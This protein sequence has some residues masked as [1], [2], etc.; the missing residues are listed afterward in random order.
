[1]PSATSTIGWTLENWGPVPET[2]TKSPSCTA[3]TDTWI[4]YTDMPVAPF[5]PEV[6][7]TATTD[8]CWP[9]PTDKSLLE[10]YADN[11][12]RVAYWS[13]GVNC[14]S[15]WTSIGQA[16]HPTDGPVT[17]SGIFQGYPGR[18]DYHGNYHL[19]DNDRT[20]SGTVMFGYKDAIGALLDPGET[21]IACCPSSM[22]VAEN[23]LC[24]ASLSSHPVSTA[25]KGGWASAGSTIVT[26]SYMLNGTAYTGPVRM[27]AT[28]SVAATPTAVT[29]TTFSAD[30]TGGL[31]AMSMEGPIFMA[32]RESDLRSLKS[33]GTSH[34]E[35]TEKAGKWD[36]CL[37]CPGPVKNVDSAMSSAT[38]YE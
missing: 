6:C 7:V 8:I 36:N 1:M 3:S 4:A 12:Y 18:A 15:G 29:T 37:R 21:A 2:Y 34:N 30:E 5:L 33:T 28:P 35:A 26:T 14:P 32:H 17:S 10:G 22:T 25:C 20:D 11:R 38:D 27:F 13:P 24:Y 31:F 9:E 16:A 23:G 19:D